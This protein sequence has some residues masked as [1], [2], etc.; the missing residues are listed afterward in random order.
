MKQKKIRV[1]TSPVQTCVGKELSKY[2]DPIYFIELSDDF[3]P[4]H[5]DCIF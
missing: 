3:V 2:V 5:A 4:N 1:K